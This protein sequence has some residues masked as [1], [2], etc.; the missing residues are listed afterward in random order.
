MD[1]KGRIGREEEIDVYSFNLNGM[2]GV[3]GDKMEGRDE[4]EG[5]EGR[6]EEYRSEEE[7][8]I[9]YV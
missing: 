3:L 9:V 4:E 1:K 2:R 6:E 7:K 8:S 5:K